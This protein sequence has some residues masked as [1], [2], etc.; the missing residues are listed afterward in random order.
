MVKLMSCQ[1]Q[2]KIKY[3]NV[4]NLYKSDFVNLERILT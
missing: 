4:I 1:N 2:K 3:K